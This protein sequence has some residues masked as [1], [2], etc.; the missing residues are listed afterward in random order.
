MDIEKEIK[1]RFY[2]SNGHHDWDHTLRVYN[3]CV[4]IGKIENVDM[5]VLKLASLLHDIGRKEEYESKGK[6]CHAERGAIL[7]RE[8]LEE[9]NY[10]KELIGKIVHCIECHRTRNDKIPKS[11]EAKILFDADKLDSLGAIGIGRIFYFAA[12][13]NARLHNKDVDISKTKAYSK[14]DTPYR[15]FMLKLRYNKDKMLTS[16]GRRIAEKRHEFMADFFNRIN[17]EVDGEI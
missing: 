10:D 14:E 11:K 2:V 3:L 17:G 1:E 16:E 7:A 13:Y 8:F 12:G 6:I 4:H 15:E 9:K 5:K